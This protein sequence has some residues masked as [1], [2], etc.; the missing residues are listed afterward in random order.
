MRE[1][2]A[3]GILIPTMLITLF[4]LHQHT[5]FAF[6]LGIFL[7]IA[8]FQC[9]SQLLELSQKKASVVHIKHHGFYQ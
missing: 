2:I 8:I 4:A 5:L 6:Q 1:I 3:L 7:P 9:A